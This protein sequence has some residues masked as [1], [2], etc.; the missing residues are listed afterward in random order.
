MCGEMHGVIFADLRQYRYPTGNVMRLGKRSS[1]CQKSTHAQTCNMECKY[2]IDEMLLKLHIPITNIGVSLL[3][4]VTV[5]QSF[6]L[7]NT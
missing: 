4:Q 6:C 7:R 1:I 5:F 3:R 2:P